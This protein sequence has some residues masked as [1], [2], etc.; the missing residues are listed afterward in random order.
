M[1]FIKMQRNGTTAEE[2][3]VIMPS[4]HSFAAGWLIMK[5]KE[6]ALPYSIFLFLLISQ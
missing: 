2:W 4:R 6:S 3:D 5:R 1:L